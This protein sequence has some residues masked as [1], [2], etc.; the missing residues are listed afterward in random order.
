MS[1]PPYEAYKDSGVGWLG[2]VPKD[3]TVCAL[4]YRYEV[5]LGK[6]LDEKRITGEH[7]GPYLRNVDV[8]WGSVNVVDLPEMDFR[9]VDLVRFSLV[10]GDLLVCEGGEVGRAAIWKGEIEPCFYQKALHR[11]RCIQ[12]RK[13]TAQFLYYVMFA[14][15]TLGVFSGSE[16]KATII[17]LPAEALR[18]YHF[19]FPS[20]PEQT[21]I[22]TFLDRETEKID[23][24][25]EEQQ[26]LIA[27]LKEKR[28]AVIS[29]AVTKGLD[30]NAPMKDSGVEWLGEVP[31]H[32]GV[33][34]LKYCASFRSGGT[35]DKANVTYWSGDIPWASAKDLKLEVLSDTQDHITDKAMQDGAAELIPA[36]SV[37]V[38]VR[39]MMLARTF[40]VVRTVV[41]TAIN[42]D[43]KALNGGPE[44][45]N[46]FLAWL[47]RG[48]SKETLNRLD[49][50]GH[51]TKALRMEAWVSLKIAV[52]PRK[53]Q[54]EI[55]GFIERQT[56][57]LDQLTSE[58]EAAIA[59]LHERRSALISAAVTGKID[60]RGLARLEA[61]A[62]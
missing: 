30:P 6:M 20:L 55:V 23:A 40:P 35:P 57:K 42:Q 38:L 45:E 44:V 34:P 58:A 51:G 24:L 56:T 5:Q 9:D 36:G 39:G 14:A 22:A 10:P 62:A 52:P 53:E 12:S 47:L 2:E 61:E 16:G 28:Q 31:A 54:D 25:V 29:H 7:L 43:L 59:L 3:W 18:R 19:A 60:V 13:D 49:E 26:R 8:Q 32:W 15:A 46:P 4:S 17:H 1:F 48:T 33:R 27:L 50:A 41:D 11:L 21:T 37:I